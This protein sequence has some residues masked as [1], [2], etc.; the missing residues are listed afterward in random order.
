MNNDTKAAVAATTIAGIARSMVHAHSPE[1]MM[2]AARAG[3]TAVEHGALATPDFT[4]PR[5]RSRR[6]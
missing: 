1:G 6:G 4:G 3:C 2:R 5:S